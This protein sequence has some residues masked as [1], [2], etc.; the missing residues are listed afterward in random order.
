MHLPVVGPVAFLRTHVERHRDAVS[1]DV[2]VGHL[3]VCGGEKEGGGGGVNTIPV[4]L[5]L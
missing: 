5:M 4:Q 1:D 2:V 3:G